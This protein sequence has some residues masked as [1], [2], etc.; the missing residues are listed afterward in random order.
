[1]YAT[2]VLVGVVAA[3][4]VSVEAVLILLI[5]HHHRHATTNSSLAI[6][7]NHTLVLL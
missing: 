2:Q 3:I 5:L 1:M 4:W 6:L 7:Q